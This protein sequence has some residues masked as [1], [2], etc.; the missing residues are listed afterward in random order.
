MKRLDPDLKASGTRRF[1]WYQAALWLLLLVAIAVVYRDWIFSLKPVGWGDWVFQTTTTM[2]DNWPPRDGW[3]GSGGIGASSATWLPA[4]LIEFGLGLAAL[5]HLPPSV[6]ERLAFLLPTLVVLVIGPYLLTLELTKSRT[7]AIVAAAAFAFNGY[8]LQ[9]AAVGHI[10]ILAA[11]GLV[12]LFVLAFV[13]LMRGVTLLRCA[14]MTAVFSALLTLDIRIAYIAAL[15]GLLM[16]IGYVVFRRA[17][18]VVAGLGA[19]AGSCAAASFILAAWLLPSLYY[20]RI[21]PALPLGYDSDRWLDVLSSISFPE[22]LSQWHSWPLPIYGAIH[23]WIPL[24]ALLSILALVPIVVRPREAWVWGFTALMLVFAFLMKG[25]QPPLAG[26]NHWIFHHVPGMYAFRDPSKFGGVVA[27]T[28]A[29]LIGYAVAMAAPYAGRFAR[30]VPAAA[31]AVVLAAHAYAFSSL[32]GGTL[33]AHDIPA[34]YGALIRYLAADRGFSRVLWL[35]TRPTFYFRSRTHPGLSGLFDASA[36]IYDYINGNEDNADWGFGYMERP[37]AGWLTRDLNVDRIV[38]IDEDSLDDST[39]YSWT[40]RARVVAMLARLPWIKF[41]RRFGGIDVYRVTAPLPIVTASSAAIALHGTSRDLRHFASAPLPEGARTAP[42]LVLADPPETPLPS[43]VALVAGPGAQS[44]DASRLFYGGLLPAAQARSAGLDF[45]TVAHGL[46]LTPTVFEQPSA[47]PG[48]RFDADIRVE[49][50]GDVKMLGVAVFCAPNT[51]ATSCESGYAIEWRKDDISLLRYHWGVPALLAERSLPLR[52]GSHHI[53]MT[54][55]HTDFGT[56]RIE[57][58]T[59]GAKALEYVDSGNLIAYE[60]R[61]ALMAAGSGSVKD[62]GSSVRGAGGSIAGPSAAAQIPAFGSTT[63]RQTR[64]QTYSVVPID[65]VN[66]AT[67]EPLLNV[68]AGAAAK[69]GARGGEAGPSGACGAASRLFFLQQPAPL[70]A[71]PTLRWS[72]PDRAAVALDLVVR[73]GERSSSCIPVPILTPQGE[74]DVRAYV[75][76]WADA[77]FAAKSEQHAK[78]Y[79]WR[80]THPVAQQPDDFVLT[81]VAVSP[82]LRTSRDAVRLDADAQLA[83]VPPVSAR[84][85]IIV[86]GRAAGTTI[87]LARGAHVLEADPSL[88]GAHARGVLL[89][90]GA[91][92]RIERID[93]VVERPEELLYRVSVPKAPCWVV[94]HFAFDSGWVAS[95]GDAVLAHR[96]SDGMFNAYYVTSPGS[97]DIEYAPRH[98]ALA[99]EIVSVASAMLLALYLGFAALRRRP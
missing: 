4:F 69:P 88:L 20:G 27:M 62:L 83:A 43:S 59:D 46:A 2:A 47:G 70:F 74:L 91:M 36:Y 24:Y 55:R 90:S 9:R 93:V 54:I 78:E 66:A 92:S 25:A 65:A 99:G 56:Q 34:E 35:P 19:I 53:H 38:V 48:S 82:A 79:A 40:P 21:G 16:G 80:F 33:R 95:A 52:P 73:D 89:A 39:L 41:E 10:T 84:P 76:S 77:D 18:H 42:V 45:V 30:L 75:A 7:A 67:R 86:D 11:D 60:G 97:I 61:I 1:D 49:T 87:R 98:L 37:Y 6:Y 94:L 96:E 28:Q 12:P 22:A 26:V 32:A 57:A 71:K 63:F 85:R 31:I 17:R 3:R 29:A 8:D 68:E 72:A 50:Q 14:A 15:V 23:P 64:P 13:K 81:G 5:V 44:Q 58:R 51:D